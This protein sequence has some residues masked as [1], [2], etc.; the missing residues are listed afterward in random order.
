MFEIRVTTRF[1]KDI[2]LLK[3]RS[4]HDLKKLQDFIELLTKFGIVGIPK[5]YKPHTLV[6]NYKD[7]YECHVGNDLLLL[8][9][10]YPY[11][12]ENIYDGIITL[13]RTGSHSDLF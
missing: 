11:E 13:V 2:K 7:T 10:E 12:Q 5:K 3:K 8:W 4:N 1:K 6:G 9:I